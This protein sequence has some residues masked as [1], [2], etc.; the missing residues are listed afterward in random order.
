MKQ[1]MQDL[2]VCLA[3]GLKKGCSQ[4]GVEYP[5]CLLCGR[6]TPYCPHPRPQHSPCLLVYPRLGVQDGEVY[7]TLGFLLKIKRSEAD[8]WGLVQGL[9]KSKA[10]WGREHPSRKE[11]SKSRRRGRGKRNRSR[12]SDKAGECVLEEPD[13]MMRSRGTFE[14]DIESTT[15][16][17]SPQPYKRRH[18]RSHRKRL[19][20]VPDEEEDLCPQKLF[21]ML[22]KLTKCLKKAWAKVRG[23]EKK[24]HLRRGAL[25]F[26]NKPQHRSPSPEG[27]EDILSIVS[28]EVPKKRGVLLN[29]KKSFLD[30]TTKKSPKRR[31]PKD[32]HET[33][34]FKKGS[35]RS[36]SRRRRA[37]HRLTEPQSPQVRKREK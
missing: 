31:T 16:P 32:H 5:I 26:L 18:R 6:C 2:Q 19:P 9:E 17:T 29:H 12:G 24:T 1:A 8:A 30:L 37:G 7:M 3:K 13:L 25:T 33:T 11:R 27:R 21:A 36:R 20:L 14:E 23:T 34:P 22:K 28:P 15:A 4:P 35:R 10:E